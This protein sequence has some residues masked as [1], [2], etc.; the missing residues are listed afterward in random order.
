MSV[1]TPTGV[2]KR[3]L[4]EI[5]SASNA[6]NTLDPAGTNPVSRT[7]WN[8]VLYC[9]I[10]DHDDDTLDPLDDPATAQE[11]DEQC[12]IFVSKF[13]GAPWVK[14]ANNLK[15]IIAVADADPVTNP[16]PGD[17]NILFPNFDYSTFE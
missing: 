17:V 14:Q 6:I 11:Q 12:A 5:S 8:Q 10:T 16:T 7:Y 2:P 1:F 13:H 15:H 4:A 3:N 9:R